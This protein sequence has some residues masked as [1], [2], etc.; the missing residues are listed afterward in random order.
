MIFTPTAPITVESGKPVPAARIYQ[1]EL[2]E[3]APGNTA[4]VTFL[5]D[6]WVAWQRLHL[7]DSTSTTRRHSPS[8]LVNIKRYTSRPGSIGSASRS[9]HGLCPG[10]FDAYSAVARDGAEQ[11]HRIS[12]SSAGTG[13]R[14]AVL[15]ATDTGEFLPRPRHRAKIS[16]ESDKILRAREGYPGPL[17]TQSFS[18]ISGAICGGLHAQVRMNRVPGSRWSRPSPTDRTN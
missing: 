14:V 9:K 5:R 16:G 10:F 7:R 18:A 17:P 3:P 12:F 2:I 8:G 1:P 11:T 15:G 13:L 6:A 4:K